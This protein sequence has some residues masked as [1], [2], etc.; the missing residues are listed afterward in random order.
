MYVY[1]A[2]LK[3]DVIL[4]KDVLSYFADMNFTLLAYYPKL[5]IIKIESKVSLKD[6][7]VRY[8]SSIE[9]EK[10]INL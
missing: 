6:V 8:I 3:E 9:Q 5:S 1:L 7:T 10:T 4:N 2:V